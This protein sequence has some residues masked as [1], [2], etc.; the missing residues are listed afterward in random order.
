MHVVTKMH[1]ALKFYVTFL[2][3]YV[4]LI[5]RYFGWNDGEQFDKGFL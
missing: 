2:P 3:L 4:S 1:D 5:R